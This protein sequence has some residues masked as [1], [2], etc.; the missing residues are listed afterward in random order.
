MG[1]RRSIRDQELDRMW[2][3]KVV[4]RTLRIL[5]PKLGEW[6]QQVPKNIRALCPETVSARNS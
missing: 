4:V 1:T 5:T 2:T 6:F 3:V